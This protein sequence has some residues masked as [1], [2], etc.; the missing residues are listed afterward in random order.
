MVMATEELKIL[1]S[2]NLTGPTWWA[3]TIGQRS[4]ELRRHLPESSIPQ[5]F[6]KCW[7]T[8][9]QATA[10]PLPLLYHFPLTFDRVAPFPKRWGHRQEKPASCR[11]EGW[12]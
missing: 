9:L 1:I 7:L 4:G 10:G 12:G 8:M 11:G 2:L 6:T 3:A 5:T